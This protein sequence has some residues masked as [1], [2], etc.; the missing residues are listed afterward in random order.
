MAEADKVHKFELGYDHRLNGQT[1]FEYNH[2]TAC[3]YVR[4]KITNDNSLVT[5]FY[6]KKQIEQEKKDG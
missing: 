2:T 1:I 4:D 3:G 6:C 5:C